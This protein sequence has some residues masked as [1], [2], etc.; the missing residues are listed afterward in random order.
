M[1]VVQNSSNWLSIACVD[2]FEMSSFYVESLDFLNFFG[3]CYE[4]I[5]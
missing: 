3:S 4:K 5:L 1:T 2:L